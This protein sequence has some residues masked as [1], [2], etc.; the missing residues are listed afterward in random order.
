MYQ[1]EGG[2]EY[3]TQEQESSRADDVPEL[4]TPVDDTEELRSLTICFESVVLRTGIVVVVL[5]VCRNGLRCCC[6][7]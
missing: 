7:C 3:G 1:D 2:F 5:V 6:R 4:T